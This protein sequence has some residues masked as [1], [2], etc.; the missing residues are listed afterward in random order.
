MSIE[1]PVK[2]MDSQRYKHISHNSLLNKTNS[3]SLTNIIIP[4]EPHANTTSKKLNPSMKKENNFYQALSLIKR[5]SNQELFQKCD[6]SEISESNV[7]SSKDDNIHFY[8]NNPLNKSISKKGN[9]IFK[10]KFL[11]SNKE[12][13]NHPYNINIMTNI[14]EMEN[15]DEDVIKSNV[16]SSNKKYNSIKNQ[17]TIPTFNNKIGSTTANTICNANIADISSINGSEKGKVVID[18]LDEDKDVKVSDYCEGKSINNKRNKLS[19]SSFKDL[20][21]ENDI[22][23]HLD[24][25]NKDDKIYIVDSIMDEMNSLNE[26]NHNV[27]ES[28]NNII[29]QLE[30]DENQSISDQGIN[31]YQF[32]ESKNATTEKKKTLIDYN[33]N[34]SVEINGEQLLFESDSDTDDKFSTPKTKI[35]RFKIENNI[36]PIQHYHKPT[37][38]NQFKNPLLLSRSHQYSKSKL[39]VSEIIEPQNK[40]GNEN[41]DA[42]YDNA[43]IYDTTFLLNLLQQNKQYEIDKHFLSNHPKLSWIIR[44]NVINIIMQVCEDF[45]FKRDTFHLCIYNTD[46]YLSVTKNKTENDLHLIAITSLSLAAKLE[47]VQI[48]NLNEYTKAFSNI[49]LANIIKEEQKLMSVLRWKAIPNT[50]NTWLNWHL[51]QWDL[52]IDGVEGIKDLMLKDYTEEQIVYFKKKDDI[53]YY[54]YRKVTQLIDLYSLDADSIKYNMQYLVVGAMLNVLIEN[55]SQEK[56]D[57]DSNLNY[58]KV[59]RLFIQESFGEDVYRSKEFRKGINYCMRFQGVEFK[60][61]IPL[62]YQANEDEI[63][64]GSYEEFI[65]FQTYNE[66]LLDFLVEKKKN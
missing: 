14:I 28:K 45:A 66:C 17:K 9:Y 51:C 4:C 39:S 24:T 46:R 59:F 48:P 11:P 13:I 20:N 15:E 3:D 30:F 55:Y 36:K 19:V 1:T 7:N 43:A 10:T 29:K 49:T 58:I 2:A 41:E 56:F 57:I 27:N 33:L 65:T 35:K 8:I 37:K 52:F 53:S 38:S 47:E 60:F 44:A 42:D 6:F 5:Q 18:D 64:K 22:A 32:P 21:D 31:Y 62:Y 26:I 12:V 16:H 61:D 23:K 63:E 50:I 54:N 34:T 25:G 40:Q